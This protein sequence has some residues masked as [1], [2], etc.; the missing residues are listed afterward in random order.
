M[1][2]IKFACPYCRQHITCDAQYCDAVIDCPACG[3]GIVVPRLC[4][5]DST[6]PERLVIASTSAP[7]PPR[8]TSIPAV[9]AMTEREWAEH[10]KKLGASEKTAP[11]WILTLIA[12]LIIAFVLQINHAGIWPIMFCLVL[13]A[14]V[15][16]VLMV[17]NLRSTG[18]YSV[19]KGL[20][21]VLAIAIFI[22][23]IAIGI[24]FIGCMGC[25]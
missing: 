19:L 21:L 24:L 11:L 12:A 2:E 4:P 1:R 18:A 8:M 15:S 20:S 6:H 23:V 7:R 9:R 17:K 25:H 5:S 16:G 3:N 14:V 10:S 13:G 22:P